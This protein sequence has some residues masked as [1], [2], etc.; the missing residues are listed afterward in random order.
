MNKWRIYHAHGGMHETLWLTDVETGFTID[1]GNT[2]FT[3]FAEH[4]VKNAI[5]L[6]IKSVQL[7]SWKMAINIVIYFLDINTYE[8]YLPSDQM[9]YRHRYKEPVSI[10]RS[11]NI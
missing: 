4:I 9:K 3:R 7:L 5:S 1:S 10:I 6:K 8:N 11:Q 2:K